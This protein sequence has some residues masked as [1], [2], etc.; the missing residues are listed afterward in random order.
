M[1]APIRKALG[2]FWESKPGPS[3]CDATVQTTQIWCTM[4]LLRGN[5]PP[6]LSSSRMITNGIFSSAGKSPCWIR[7]PFK[8]QAVRHWADTACLWYPGFCSI[9]ELMAQSELWMSSFICLSSSVALPFPSVSGWLPSLL[10]EEM[11]LT[12]R[13]HICIGG[14]WWL[15]SPLVGLLTLRRLLQPKKCASWKVIVMLILCIVQDSEPRIVSQWKDISEW[16]YG[17]V[18]SAVHHFGK[19]TPTWDSTAFGILFCLLDFLVRLFL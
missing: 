16:V 2:P 10:D 11:L 14:L 9:S 1:H 6:A 7:T 8:S 18:K 4:C 13:G 19:E 5:N 3:H 12:E 15:S 17:Q